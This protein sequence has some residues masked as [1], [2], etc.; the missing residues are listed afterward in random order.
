[1]KNRPVKLKNSGSLVN[2]LMGHNDSVP[3]VGKGATICHWSDRDAYEVL[4]FDEKKK[5]VVIQ[6]YVPKRIDNNGMGDSQTYEYKELTGSKITLYFKW[7]SWKTKHKKFVFTDEA[8]KKYGTNYKT[9]H[10]E[11][12]AQGGK[13]AGAFIGSEVKGLTRSKNE[14]NSVNIIFGIKQ[15]FYDFTF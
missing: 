5:T 9:M 12:K 11:F 10:E 2:Y 1:M 14:W 7:G 3:E 6:R 4:E 13:Y 8:L 15:E